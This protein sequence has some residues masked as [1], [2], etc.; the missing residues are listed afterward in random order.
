M[1]ILLATDGS[2]NAAAAGDILTRLPL[3]PQSALTIL[4]VID[5]WQTLPAF[6]EMVTDS[7]RHAY[8][9]WQQVLRHEA[10]Q[11]LAREQARFTETGWTVHTDLRE[12][13]AAHQI[14]QAATELKTDLVV[15]GSRGLSGVKRFIL[16]SVSQQVITHAPC[17]VLVARE[18]QDNDF[19]TTGSATA[20]HGGGEAPWR[21]I[22]AD[23][24]SP[25]A[26][27]AIEML[28]LLPLEARTEILLLTVLT[29]ITAYRM[30]I[31]QTMSASWQE[32]KQAA[33]ARLD[34]SAQMLRR[35]TP[36]VTVQLREGEDPSQEIVDAAQ[37]FGATLIVMG[38]RGRSSI[39]RFLLGSVANRVVQHAPC[40]VWVVRE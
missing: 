15:V 35:A 1:K 11:L 13:H 19:E 29:L 2:P 37:A 12:G 31:L 33:Q 3:P 6:E 4:T 40:S 32:K 24:G 21:L 16:G 20:Q 39:E 18:P 8:Q 22:V 5:T 10:E 14:V 34:R 26:Q 36:H 17:S 9:Q 23:D 7:E 28:A 30:D 27:K 38:H 25:M